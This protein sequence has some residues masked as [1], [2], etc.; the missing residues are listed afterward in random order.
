MDEKTTTTM[1]TT[2][3]TTTTTANTTTTTAMVTKMVVAVMMTTATKE[4]EGWHGSV[5]LLSAAARLLDWLVVLSFG[6]SVCLS[7]ARSGSWPGSRPGSRL[8]DL[9]CSLD[10]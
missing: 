9:A 1:T 2:T 10:S 8:E 5:G 6:H 3:M 4:Q 7:D